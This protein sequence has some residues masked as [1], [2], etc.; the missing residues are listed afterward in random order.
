MTRSWLILLSGLVGALVACAG[1]Y[2][3]A[4][5]PSRSWEEKARPELAWL[6][7]EHR[8]SDADYDRICELHSAYLPACTQMRQVIETKTTQLRRLLAGATR[9]TPEI[10]EALKEVALL[11][12]ECQKTLL[13]HFYEVSRAM[14]PAEGQRYLTMMQELSLRGG[15]RTSTKH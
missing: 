6:R 2:F 5:K 14:P 1:V 12:A 10:A 7:Q 3:A 8:L 9:V 11:R 15:H 4:T 13:D